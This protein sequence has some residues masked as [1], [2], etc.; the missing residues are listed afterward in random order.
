MSRH[1]APTVS[2]DVN[3]DAALGEVPSRPTPTRAPRTATAPAPWDQRR[4]DHHP[5]AHHH[6]RRRRHHQRFHQAAHNGVLAARTP[7]DPRRHVVL[8]GQRLH[9]HHQIFGGGVL[10][11]SPTPTLR[12][13]G[14]AACHALPSRRHPGAAP[15][16]R[17]PRFTRIAASPSSR[18]AR[19]GDPWAS[20]STSRR[21]T[22]TSPG[23]SGLGVH[24]TGT[25][26]CPLR[27]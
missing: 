4:R 2:P 20:R 11:I 9:G 10:A 18:A 25:A 21:A 7:Q 27:P 5:T 24:Q 14:R 22:L 8:A 26:R 13:P 15:R 16:L 6:R 1:P 3:G 23:R 19:T 12:R 17:P